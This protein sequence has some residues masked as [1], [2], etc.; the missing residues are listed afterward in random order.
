[1]PFRFQRL[2][3]PE[4]VLIET[5]TSFDNRGFFMELYKTSEFV[6]N[7][8]PQTFVQDNYSHSHRG[9]LRGLHY[10]QP[11]RAQGKLVMALKGEIFDVAVDIRTGSP[12][13]GQ[14]AGLVL[15]SERFRMLYVP[16]GFAHG[17]CVLSEEAS[18]VYKVT[19]EYAPD[20]DRGIVWN[21]P[22]IGIQWPITEP[23]L[24]QKDAQ[25][26]L[27]SE[28]ANGLGID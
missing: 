15:S 4:V 7:G 11:P 28:A 20:L 17:F 5:Q 8:I 1:M 6:A 19:E 13:Y 24:S 9:V 21:D 16:A 26:P 18:V 23:T 3:I 2:R 10:Q 14:W 12:T 22:D 27:L 25:L